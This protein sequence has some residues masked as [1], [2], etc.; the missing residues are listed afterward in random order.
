MGMFWEKVSR[1][2]AKAQRSRKQEM[3]YH[4]IVSSSPC[5]FAPLREHLSRLPNDLFFQI[6][7]KRVAFSSLFFILLM[8][9]ACR[10]D[11]TRNG[12]PS[13]AQTVIDTVTEDIA[14]ADTEKIYREAADEWRRAATPEQSNAFFATLRAKLGKV[15]SRTFTSGKEQQTASNDLAGHAVIVTYQTK[16]ERAEGM[17]TFTLVERNGRW[18]LARYFVNSNALKQ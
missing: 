10:V 16:F 3:L 2:G 8:G 14:S 6:K 12:I 18:M 11:Q 1:K 4:A 17:E 9:C 15:E 7:L 13:E 5:A